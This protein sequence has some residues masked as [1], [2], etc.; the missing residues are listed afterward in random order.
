MIEVEIYR[1]LRRASDAADNREPAEHGETSCGQLAV[2]V[3]ESELLLP[4]AAT[5]RLFK[6]LWQRSPQG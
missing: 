2:I 5:V 4:R 3:T 6:M 1:P